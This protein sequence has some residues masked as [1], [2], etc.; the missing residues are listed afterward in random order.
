MRMG[1]ADTLLCS[2]DFSDD[3]GHADQS[4]VLWHDGTRYVGTDVEYTGS[5]GGET[6]TCTV[7]P[8]DGNLTGTT[9]ADSLT[10]DNSPPE[11]VSVSFS[12][13]NPTTDTILVAT[14]TTADA[15]VDTVSVTY[16]WYVNTDEVQSGASNTLNGGTYF[17]K[18]DTIVLE[19]VPN[20]T[21]VD[22]AL[23]TS[24]TLTVVNATPGAP[25]VAISPDPADAN[26]SL[27][28]EI[29]GAATDPDDDD[30]SYTF[31]WT[32]NGESVSGY[33]TTFQ[34]DTQPVAFTAAD[35]V[36]VC[37]AVA[38]D[39]Q[40]GGSAQ[41]TLTV[42]GCDLEPT[43]IRDDGPSQ[44]TWMTDPLE[45]LGA[46]LVWE[47]DEFS[48]ISYVEEYANE[49]DFQTLNVART[50]TLE[51]TGRGTGMAMYGGYLY[52]NGNNNVVIKADPTDGSEVARVT[53]PGLG[54]AS[55]C[56]WEWGGASFLEV[57]AD[58]SGLW[59]IYGNSTDCGLT[60]RPMGTDLTL[61]SAI[62][63]GAAG[64]RKSLGNAFIQDGVIFAVNMF[65]RDG[66]AIE[67]AM[68][69]TT[70]DTWNPSLSVCSQ[71]SYL[72][73]FS[74]NPAT[75]KVL[76][77]DQGY[78]VEYDMTS[79]G[80]PVG[81]LPTNPALSCDDALTDGASF[82]D[83]QYWIDPDSSGSFQVFCDM[84]TDGG[85]WTAVIA[86]QDHSQDY[87]ERFPMSANTL[88]TWVVDPTY[89]ASFGL[90]R[91]NGTGN[92]YGAELDLSYDEVRLTATGF[93][94]DPAGG[95]GVL[96]LGSSA[97]ATEL[98]SLLD[99]HTNSGEGQSL[100]VDGVS[101]FYQQQTDVVLT[102]YTVDATGADLLS[103]YMH[104]L[105]GYGYTQRY[106]DELWIR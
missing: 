23:F 101:I 21:V 35:D 18:A 104:G 99:G 98:M 8:N 43:L 78:Q 67:F 63:A 93:Y 7:K 39:T 85:G 40:T 9:G 66:R 70:G 73:Q 105:T 4:T 92:P 1:T 96:R 83:G 84:T 14:P 49:A 80:P 47:A 33:T 58:E 65:Q 59:L 60:V 24:N 3:D 62:D 45:T 46:G 17:D 42:G 6:L 26:S 88:S 87:F 13:V 100:S 103:I 41:D 30:V 34:G 55:N 89:G 76:A 72:A 106:V 74:Y 5:V 36:F 52:Y 28:C 102:E 48:L 95:L 22:G 32:R 29:T 25:T 86:P 64:Y 94:D 90:P 37:T 53:V 82:G 61:G 68:D 20:D 69:L 27:V 31:S 44:G 10:L 51:T 91:P 57:A 81:L 54:L 77:W 19:M 11:V 12:T 50:I 97:E 16:T 56:A 75:Q 38:K 79:A 2:W 71:G 15:D